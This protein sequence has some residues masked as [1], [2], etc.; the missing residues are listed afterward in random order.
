MSLSITNI[1]QIGSTLNVQYTSNLAPT[2]DW[3]YT[4]D[5]SIYTSFICPD[6]EGGNNY[7]LPISGLSIGNYF[8]TIKVDGVP[9]VA[10]GPRGRPITI[11][12]SAYPTTLSAPTSPSVTTPATV[13]PGA[14]ILDLGQYATGTSLKWYAA[15]TGGSALASSTS[16]TTG[17]Y[18]VSQTVDGLES[19]RATVDVTVAPAPTTSTQ[20]VTVLGSYT[21]IV[22]GQ[23]YTTSGTYTHTVTQIINGITFDKETITLNLTIV[24]L[25][26]TPTVPTN[27]VVVAA[28]DPLSS[29]VQYVSGILPGANLYW[30]ENATGGSELDT[31]TTTFTTPRTYYVIQVSSAGIDSERAAISVIFDSIPCFAEGTRV[32]TQSGYKAIETLTADDRIVTS[33][34]RII[35]FKRM[36][37]T[38]RTTTKRTAPYLVQPHAFGHN[39]PAAPVRLS[40]IHKI[41]IGKGRWIS[42]EV[43]AR[44]NPLVTQCEIGGPIT[45]YHIECENYLRDNLVTEGL[46]VESFGSRKAVGGR[47]DIY[48]WNERLNAYTRVGT[49]LTNS[50]SAK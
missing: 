22:K 37:T 6:D 40:P 46:T 48:T 10:A 50:A 8:V 33:D 13:N 36:K 27:A 17:A 32:L 11:Y 28:G 26:P 31:G 19:D 41:Q 49:A 4:V 43:A 20:N 14:T 5:G 9:N 30:Y 39:L 44:T 34:R 12:S 1:V 38:L 35:A 45:Y 42:P 29:L 16:L 21:W 18:Y 7:T 15:A 24:P 25:S 47:K 2:Y 3:S 23:T